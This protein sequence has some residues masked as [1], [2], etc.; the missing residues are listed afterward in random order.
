[1]RWYRRLMYWLRFRSQSDGLREELSHH[2]SLLIKENERR[3]LSPADARDSARRAMGN[4]TF[5]REEA[6]GVWLAPTI[7]AV[8]Q[9]LRYAWRGLRSQSCS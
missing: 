8:L 9:D 4:E 2:A 7:E 6:R 3:G 1:M 5:M